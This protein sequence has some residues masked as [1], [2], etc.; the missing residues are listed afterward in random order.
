V[1]TTRTTTAKLAFL[2]LPLSIAILVLSALWTLGSA[3]I[4]SS[5]P[6]LVIKTIIITPEE[7][8]AEE[9]ISITAVIENQGRERVMLPFN[10]SFQIGEEFL[11]TVQVL[12][13]LGPR[14]TTE[15]SRLWTAVE[16]EHPL[17]VRVDPFD[18]IQ[19]SN[20]RNNRR[21]L[22]V[23]VKLP[24]GVRSLTLS[25][26]EAIAEG[27]RQAGEALHVQTNSDLFQLFEETKSAS[28]VAQGAFTRGAQQLTALAQILP[29]A[30]Q[31]EPQI[32]T[33]SHVAERYRSMASAFE[34]AGEGIQRLNLQLLI[35]AFESMREDLAA[36][37]TV[38]IE[39]VSLAG[40]EESVALMDQ[41][42]EEARQLEQA[43]TGEA[44]V[45]VEAAAQKFLGV[46]AEIG[47]HWTRVA[48]DVVQSG[49]AKTAR[50]TNAQ[51][52]PVLRY[53][54]PEALV[55]FVPDVQRF[56]FE[57]FDESGTLVL[58][59]DAQ[60]DRLR[61]TGTDA[62]GMPLPPGRY[63]YRLTAVEAAGYTRTELGRLVIS[64]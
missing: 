9:V 12:D 11:G 22:T 28:L 57:L 44:D 63:F 36:L 35:R 2:V 17:I 16:G 61:W 3:Q 30:L 25:L 48:G 62:Q 59:Q 10:V 54:P 42:L 58:A 46:L 50:F 7:P 14:E 4:G 13:R 15:V 37:A 21:Q 23:V 49:Q 20:E 32:Q 18:S 38:A 19:E 26:F 24:Q 1:F 64:E 55:I 47:T 39:G 29:P 53:K 41:A 33:G 45:D 31:G 6:D 56:R 8:E 52:D 40:L 51:N 5:L 27:L 34:R 60:G 43:A